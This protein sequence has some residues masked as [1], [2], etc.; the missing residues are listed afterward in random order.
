[1]VGLLFLTNDLE[2]NL[3]GLFAI[4]KNNLLPHAYFLILISPNKISL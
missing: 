1:M 2:L 3:L 4:I